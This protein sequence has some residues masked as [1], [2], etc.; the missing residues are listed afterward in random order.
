MARAGTKIHDQN[1]TCDVIIII[2][3]VIII[4]VIV[5]YVATTYVTYDVHVLY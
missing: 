1:S 5:D 3:I 2:V 4:V